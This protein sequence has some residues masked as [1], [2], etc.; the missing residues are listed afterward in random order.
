MPVTTR[1]LTAR[2]VLVSTLSG[3]IV[4][5]IFSRLIMA[6]IALSIGKP[7]NL[8]VLGLVEVALVG[9]LMGASGGVILLA[10]KKYMP[11]GYYRGLTLGIVLY[12]GSLVFGIMGRRFTVGE[13]PYAII[14]LVSTGGIYALYGILTEWLLSAGHRDPL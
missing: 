10:I 7:T 4:L 1:G 3:A 13:N 5:G 2:I 6:A 8:S 9:A 14:I 12:G 11:P